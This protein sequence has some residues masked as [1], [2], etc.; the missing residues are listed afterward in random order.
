MAKTIEQ[1]N[2]GLIVG[3][4]GLG[5]HGTQVGSVAQAVHDG[6]TI[7]VRAPGDFGIRFLGVDAP[8]VSAKLPDSGP[9]DYPSLSSPRWEAFLSGEPLRNARVSRGLRLHLEALLGPGVAAN[10]HFHSQEARKGLAQMVEADRAALGQSKEDFRFFLAFAYEVMDGYG[11]FLAFIHPNDPAR[12]LPPPRRESYNDRMLEAGLVLPYFIWPNTDP[13]LKARL[14]TS[15][16][17]G[18]VLSPRQLFEEAS[19][20][21]TKLGCARAAVRRA[22]AQ[23]IGLFAGANPLRL[24]PSEL[25]LLVNLAKGRTVNRWVIDLSDPKARLLHPEDYPAIPHPE[26]RLFV[27]EE[28]V[29]LFRQRGW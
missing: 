10:H 20:P 11:R 7:D 13:F 8:E 9:D 2:S 16:L 4:V 21:A 15:S 27:A 18:A 17:Q 6:D 14:A 29:P 28:F 25:R 22:R 3:R 1:L 23:Q 24:P 19:D 5:M 12:Q 26:D